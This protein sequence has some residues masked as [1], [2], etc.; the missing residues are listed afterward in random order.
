MKGITVQELIKD[1][2][3][4]LELYPI[5]GPKG[6]SRKIYNP[7][8]QKLGLVITGHMVYLHPNR[9]QIL[10]NTEISYLRLLGETESSAIIQELCK[11]DVVC[12]VVTRNLEAPDHFLAETEDKDIP[13]LRTKLITSVFIERITRYLEE[14]LAPST[15]VHGVL[16][17]IL[18]IG[19]LIRKGRYRQ[20]AKMP[21]S[22]LCGDIDWLWMMSCMQKRWAQL[23]FAG[24]PLIW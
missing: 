5:A 8:I 15:T 13:L 4:R 16:M 1:K 9:M 10:G 2:T 24:S 14:K 18:G 12:F 3:H 6:L 19:T 7:R 22:S 20:R 17:D 21:L 23:I 11:N